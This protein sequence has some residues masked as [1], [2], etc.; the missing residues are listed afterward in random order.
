MKR[1]DPESTRLLDYLVQ[2]KL[3]L[4]E[5]REAILRWVGGFRLSRNAVASFG[6]E[7]PI[8][9]R[10]VSHVK[11]VYEPGGAPTAKAYLTVGRAWSGLTALG[12][13]TKKGK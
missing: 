6:E 11:I 3:C 13:T 10:R 2:K 1:D 4:P 9:L 5:K 8:F 12:T 7:T